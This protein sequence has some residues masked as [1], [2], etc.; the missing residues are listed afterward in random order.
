MRREEKE[1]GGGRVGVV[2]RVL[3]HKYLELSVAIAIGVNKVENKHFLV[4]GLGVRLYQCFG[5]YSC[6]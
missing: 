1:E 4:R 2:H 5:V 3:D 6:S